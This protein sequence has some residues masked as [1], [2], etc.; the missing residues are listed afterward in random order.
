MSK[1]YKFQEQ[2][3]IGKE[4]EAKLDKFFKE[5][6][7]MTIKPVSI[8]DEQSFGFDRK[9]VKNDHECFIEYKTDDK[10]IKTGN[11]FI[12][13]VSNS[14]NGKLGWVLTSHA[15]RVAILVASTVYLMKMNELREYIQAEG[16]KYRLATAHNP[17]YVS[18]G[19]LMP[20]TDLVK[21]KSLKT[22]T[23]EE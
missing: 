6:L 20:I 19:R 11:L 8:K 13:T 22:Y 4:G 14:N 15:S 2:L 12:E 7:G 21:I 17:T 10:A 23:I 3:Q 5:K 1:I 9:F 16:S 18:K